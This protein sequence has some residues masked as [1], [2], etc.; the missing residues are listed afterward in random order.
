M[1]ARDRP[2]WRLPA[3]PLTVALL[4]WGGVLAVLYPTAAGWMSEVE[5][6]RSV[7]DYSADTVTED[8]ADRAEKL[9]DAHAYNE[10]LFGG[11]SVGA[12]ERIPQADPARSAPGYAEQL[13]SG[14]DGPL[15]RLKIPAIDVD[16]PIY[17]GTSDD[18]LERGVG[19]LE[20]T[21]LPVGGTGTHAVLTGHRGLVSAE[22]FTR[23]DEVELD[24]SFTIEVLGEAFVYRVID[25]RIVEPDET[26][27][28]NPVAGQDLVTLVTCTPLGINSHRILVTA[29]RVL[30]TPPA[31][32]ALTGR[33]ATGPGF[34]WWIV[35]AAA[36]LVA[37]GSYVWWAG[38]QE[39]RI[40]GLRAR[41][42]PLSTAG[43]GGGRRERLDQGIDDPK[44]WAATSGR[45]AFSNERSTK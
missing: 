3:A 7:D 34:P 32:V 6:A 41:H 15:G 35:L 36:T 28:L 13:R 12:N 5:Q 1:P 22:L 38:V 37:L 40:Q 26:Q 39:A 31:D 30:P 24:D 20:G 2:R 21:A 44:I 27:P 42:P 25:T 19:H 18:V 9:R 43:R 10:Q 45:S 23:L 16:L 11:A 33:D 8:P 29:E 17:H 14:T 4:C